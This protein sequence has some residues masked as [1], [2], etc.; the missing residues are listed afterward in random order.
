MKSK[1]I[2][3]VAVFV[4]MLALA[5]LNLGG[6]HSYSLKKKK[7]KPCCFCKYEDD[8]YFLIIEVFIL[9]ITWKYMNVVLLPEK[10]CTSN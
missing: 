1:R 7:K 2:D 9:K 6:G 5:A 4:S 3:E 8:D 10:K